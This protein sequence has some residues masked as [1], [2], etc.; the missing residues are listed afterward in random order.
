MMKRANAHKEK[1]RNSLYQK[2]KE[3]GQWYWIITN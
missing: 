1:V 3:S 2:Q